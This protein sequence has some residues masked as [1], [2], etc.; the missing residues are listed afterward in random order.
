MYLPFPLGDARYDTQQV[1][2][3]LFDRS[4]VRLLCQKELPRFQEI[5][6]LVFVGNG[7]RHYVQFCKILDWILAVAAHG[8]HLDQGLRSLVP[9]VFRAA[10]ALGYPAGMAFL[11]ARSH[12]RTQ[13]HGVFKYLPFVAL[14]YHLKHLVGT[15]KVP[16]QIV[17]DQVI[18]VRNHTRGITAVHQYHLQQR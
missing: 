15:G 8:H 11:Y 3:F 9:A 4:P 6:R 10:V 12:E 2:P 17:N 1:L 18:P 7:D 16:R 5:T 13:Y 14:T